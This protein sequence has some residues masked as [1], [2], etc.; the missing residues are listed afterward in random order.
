MLGFTGP[1]AEAEE[2]RQR[3][4]VFLRG[5][6]ALELSPEKT[7]ITHARTRAARFPGYEISVQHADAKVTRGRRSVNGTVALRVPLDVIRAKC[8]LY[9]QRGTP[10]HRSRLQNLDDYDIV[11]IYGAE[12]RGIANYYLL[13]QDVWRLGALRWNA[14]TSMLKTLA[15]THESTVTKMAARHKA[16]SRHRTG[17]ARALRPGDGVRARRTWS[18]GPAGY[19]WSA[20]GAGSSPTRPRSRCP[21]P[22]RS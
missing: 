13:A 3:L 1:K 8:S 20:T 10:W 2:I 21:S 17:C 12:Y 14:V 16:R 7:L 6:L 19:H 5:E 11:R 9:R 18:R 15:A 4:A 22:A